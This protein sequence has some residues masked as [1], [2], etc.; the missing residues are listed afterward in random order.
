MLIVLP[1]SET[2]APPPEIGPV[3]DLE[4]L[5]FPEL[6]PIRRRVLEALVE[7]SARPDGLRRLMV[8][9]TLAGEVAR[10][11][12][13]FDVPTRPAAE[14]YTG[15]LHAGFDVTHLDRTARARLDREIVI[16]SA[17]WG[18]VRP[19]D[20]VPTYRLSIHAHLVGI[21]RLDATWRER[22][23][24]V[25][26][27]AAGRNGLIVDMRSTY[28]Q[29]AGVPEEVGDR[30]VTVRVPQHARNGRR[31]GDVVAKRLRGEA[32]HWL[33]E[34]G[35]APNDPDELAAILG[36]QWPAELRE[37]DRPGKSWTL[38]LRAPD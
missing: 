5:S 6:L 31:I 36:E 7:T 34:S 23:P 33:L 30:T 22:L 12:H 20:R 11:T 1:P 25:L 29:A 2:K 38:T 9:P 16:T 17:L 3:L 28:Y 35:A 37:P 21:D 32:A 15:P 26:A 8:R 14:V 24:G 4:A 19:G 18:A 10:N 13:L 27:A